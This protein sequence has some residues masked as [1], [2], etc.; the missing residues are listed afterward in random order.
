MINLFRTIGVKKLNILIIGANGLI[1]GRLANFFIKK[2]SIKVFKIFRKDFQKKDFKSHFKNI[3]IVINCI[4]SDMNNSKNYK[5]TE[6]I[7]YKIPIKLFKIAN[8]LNVKYFIFISTFH[9]YKLVKNKVINET[10]NLE[11]RNNYNKSKIL[12]EKKLLREKKKTKLIIIRSCNLF[13]YPVSDSKNCWKLLINNLISNFHQNKKVLIKSNQDE[14]RVY[15]SI[16]SFCIFVFNLIRKIEKINFKNNFFI[17][18]YVTNYNLKISQVLKIITFFFKNKYKLIKYKYPNYYKNSS[19]YN[20][21][22]KYQKNF[23]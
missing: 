9:V 7:N 1:G 10:S 22:S 18:N 11:I 21:Q 17:I 2:N 8:E 15:S 16:E 23:K 3:D 4:G 20:F 6:N 13:G 14:S 12:C 19:I 5:F